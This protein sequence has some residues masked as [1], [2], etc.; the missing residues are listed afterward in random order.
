MRYGVLSISVPI[1]AIRG[2]SIPRVARNVLLKIYIVIIVDIH[3]PLN[4]GHFVLSNLRNLKV[5]FKF[6]HFC[7]PLSLFIVPNNSGI[8]CL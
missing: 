3:F 8:P 7:A 6:A 4:S 5:N 1:R 2:Q